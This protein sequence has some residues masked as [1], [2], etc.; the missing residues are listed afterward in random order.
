MCHLDAWEFGP[1]VLDLRSVL[2]IFH[3]FYTCTR[4]CMSTDYINRLFII[5]VVPK[6]DGIATPLSDALAHRALW[7]RATS[8]DTGDTEKCCKSVIWNYSC[9]SSRWEAIHSTRMLFN[10]SIWLLHFYRSSLC[11][12]DLDDISNEQKSISFCVQVSAVENFSQ[13]SPTQPKDGDCEMS[14]FAKFNDQFETAAQHNFQRPVND[15][16]NVI[17]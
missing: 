8:I 15:R 11:A 17:T 12:A 7:Y 5:Y 1:F 2:A 16:L 13:M 10:V 14:P 3:L 9:F 6:S 4:V